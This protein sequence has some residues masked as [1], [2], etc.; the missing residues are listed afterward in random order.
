[1]LT[2]PPAVCHIVGFGG[3][4]VDYVLRFWSRAPPPGPTN[5]RGNVYLALGDAFQEQGISFPFPRREVRM[6]D[7]S[8]ANG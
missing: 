7:Q 5:I 6:L 8:G 4:S 1:V 2:D 3:S